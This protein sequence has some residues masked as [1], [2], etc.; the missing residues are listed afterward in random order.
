MPS[1]FDDVETEQYLTLKEVAQFLEISEATVRNWMKKKMIVP[2]KIFN[3]KKLFLKSDIEQIKKDIEAGNLQRLQSRRNKKAIQGEAIPSEY[4]TYKPYINIAEKICEL[5]KTIEH[6]HK[7]RLLLLEIALT[8][9][10]ERKKIPSPPDEN[11]SFVETLQ[12]KALDLKPYEPILL[13]LFDYKNHMFTARDLHKL[14]KIRALNIPF[15]EGEDVLG[16]VYLSLS[17]IGKRKNRGSYYTPSSIVENVVAV[18]L[19]HLPDAK[20]KTFLDPCC[21]SGNFLLKIFLSLRSEWLK[22]GKNIAKAEQHILQR[23]LFGYDI[24]EVAAL[25]CKINLVLHLESPLALQFTPNVFVQNTLTNIDKQ[26]K[27]DCIIGNPPWGASFSPEEATFFK[28]HYEIAQTSLESFNL[29]LERSLNMLNDGGILSFVLPEALLNVKTHEKMRKRLL[30]LT[31]ILHIHVLGHQFSKVFAPAVVLTV[32]KEKAL[33]SHKI[34]IRHHDRQITIQ[35]CRF[36]N[37]EQ[38][39]FNVHASDE[40][41]SIIE[42]MRHLKN[43][44]TLKNNA[45]FALG[46]VTGNNQEF[47]KEKKP[48]NGEMILKGNDIFKYNYV[49]DKQFIVYEREKFQQVAPDELYR[50][51]EKL[52]YRF[53]NEQLIFAY[54]NNQTLTLNSAN[55]VIPKID[56]LHLKYILAVL[57]SRPAQFFH[58]YSFSSVKVLRKHIESIPIPYVSCEKQAGII[59]M[60]EELM[61]TAVPQK[62]NE[63]YESID[64]EIMNLFEFTEKQKQL[65]REKIPVKFLNWQENK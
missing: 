36:Y 44:V 28:Q 19:N 10:H 13:E 33:K 47:I 45:Q 61:Q 57:N 6:E 51:K 56:G 14:R 8:L 59:E 43:H 63:L 37:N 34:H 42:H 27:Y 9:L 3:R 26:K 58:L 30:T 2:Q 35:Q 22:S 7:I 39:I 31:S 64:L 49:P 55:I 50:A 17:N 65:I 21:G 24:D 5:A 18:T 15:I 40:E 29:F 41:T 62:R 38:F 11:A 32:K 1:L 25:L 12:K 20:D 46:I 52:V 4:V 54:D 53:I 23:Q 48:K 16:L 60:A